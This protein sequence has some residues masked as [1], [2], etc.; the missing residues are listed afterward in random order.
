MV[1][2]HP[3]SASSPGLILHHS[4]SYRSRVVTHHRLPAVVSLIAPSPRLSVFI[5]SLACLSALSRALPPHIACPQP[6]HALQPHMPVRNPLMHFALS[7]AYLRRRQPR[8]LSRL[9]P[10]LSFRLT[11]RPS[12]TARPK[13]MMHDRQHSISLMHRRPHPCDSS[14]AH[15]AGTL[16]TSS[17]T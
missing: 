17:D 14:S 4:L 10:D 13:H 15:G 11:N 6:S 16:L 8:S 2:H 3:L 5:P 7:I 1:S 12:H 9:P